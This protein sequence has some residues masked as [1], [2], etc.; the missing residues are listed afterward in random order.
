MA[1][2][3][4][5]TMKMF[6]SGREFRLWFDRCVAFAYSYI[7]DFSES[8]HIASEAIIVLWQKTS[9]GETVEAPLPFL[10]SVVRNK[11]LKYLRHK[12]V[13]ARAGDELETQANDSIQL[14]I[15]SL[16]SCDPHVLYSSEVQSII[17]GTLSKMPP[18]TKDIFVLSRFMGWTNREIA[19]EIGLA[20]KSVEYHITKAIRL[21]RASLKDYLPSVAI[22]LGL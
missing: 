22:L 15:D 7:S 13:V 3:P 10:F 4:V 21:M 19:Q 1:T 20:E 16:E 5:N 6:S 2:E 18:K 8:E 17:S 14:R 11:A 9:A 12:K